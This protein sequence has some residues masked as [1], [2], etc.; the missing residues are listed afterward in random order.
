MSHRTGTKNSWKASSKQKLDRRLGP[1][2]VFSL[3]K[4]LHSIIKRKTT[5]RQLQTTTATTTN[6]I[7]K[8]API[9]FLLLAAQPHAYAATSNSKPNRLRGLR[10]TTPQSSLALD[11]SSEDNSSEGITLYIDVMENK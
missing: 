10:A 9:A 2:G 6:M 3:R 7:T 1:H 5:S 11:S 8:I 4:A